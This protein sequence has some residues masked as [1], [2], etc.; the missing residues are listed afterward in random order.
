MERLI[1]GTG[2]CGSTPLSQMLS[3]HR[4]ALS[5]SELFHGIDRARRFATDGGDW[6]ALAEPCGPGP[7]LPGRA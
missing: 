4:G 7:V 2:R 6:I 3:K 5:V 1:V